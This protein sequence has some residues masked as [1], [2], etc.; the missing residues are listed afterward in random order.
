MSEPRMMAVWDPQTGKEVRHFG[1]EARVQHK[2]KQDEV[3]AIL[4]SRLD[5]VRI[6]EPVMVVYHHGMK[7][8]KHSRHMSVSNPS[9]CSGGF[10]FTNGVKA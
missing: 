8:Y 6:G 3:R 7:T 9:N 1:Y 4:C 5:T 10:Y 2:S